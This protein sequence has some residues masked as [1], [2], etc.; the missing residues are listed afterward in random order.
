[1]DT[2]G[3]ED[4]EIARQLLVDVPAEDLAAALVRIRRDARPAPE[5]ITPPPSMRPRR[6]ENGPPRGPLPRAFQQR[7]PIRDERGPDRGPPRDHRAPDRSPPRDDRSPPRDDRGPPRDDRASF[8]KTR[9]VAPRPTTTAAA[10]PRPR[11]QAT[12]PR[13]R[14]PVAASDAVPVMQSEAQQRSERESGPVRQPRQTPSSARAD[15]VWF[16]VNVGR[17]KNADPK[18]LIPFLC[19]RGDVTKR[20]IGKIEILAKETRVEISPTDAAHF[21]EAIQRPDTKDKNLHIERTEAE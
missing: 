7:M 5:V 2:V 14:D 1:M 19:R 11:G 4:R 3:D 15:G 16:T 12:V 18:W 20:S 8:G 9:E 21:A 6:E 13:P 17:L 10:T